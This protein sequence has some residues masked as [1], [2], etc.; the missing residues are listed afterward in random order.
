[1]TTADEVLPPVQP[2]PPAPHGL[3]EVEAAIWREMA[4]ALHDKSHGWRIGVLATT[5]GEFADARHVVLRDVDR[6]ARTLL[7]Y[8]DARSPKVRQVA[9]HPLGTLVLWSEALGWQLRLRV[10]LRLETEGLI[11]SS[12]WARLK[13][14]PGARDY[15]SPLAPGSPLA[16][17][18][19][20]RSSRAH[21]AVLVAD[22]RSIDWLDLETEG[23]RRARFDADGA[24]WLAP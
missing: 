24:R 15:M 23:H 9:Q 6:A 7:V 20:Q 17:P 18:S 13:M 4:R 1:M 8:T 10:A 5:D 21:F 22:V 16:R 12:R 19:P 11:V 2:A 3:A 14:T